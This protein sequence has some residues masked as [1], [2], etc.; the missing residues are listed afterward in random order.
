L[1]AMDQAKQMLEFGHARRARQPG[2][3]N[4]PG[5]VEIATPEGGLDLGKIGIV[6]HCLR[7]SRCAAGGQPCGFAAAAMAPYV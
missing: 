6:L 2:L 3:G 7:L 4:R 5:A 1:P